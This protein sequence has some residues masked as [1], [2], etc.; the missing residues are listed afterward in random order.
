[1]GVVDR[2]TH[3]VASRPRN[4]IRVP[5][6]WKDGFSMMNLQAWSDQALHA[7]NSTAT[8]VGVA[9]TAVVLLCIVLIYFSGNELTSR[10]M[11]KRETARGTPPNI[12]AREEARPP[13]GAAEGKKAAAASRVAQLEAE[14]ESARHSDD[15]NK[16]RAAQLERELSEARLAEKTNAARLS[17][18]QTDLGKVRQSDEQKESRVAQL[19]RELTEARD[20]EKKTAARLAQLETDLANSR[21]ADEEKGVRLAQMD[22]DLQKARQ[23]TDQA[24]AETKR[25]ESAEGPR[26]ITPEQRKQFIESVRGLPTGKVLVSAFF[27]NPET[28][29][30]GAELLGLLKSAGFSVVERAPLNFFTT[31]R[32]SSGVR[33]GCQDI[34]NPPPH[35]ETVRKALESI[36][37]D[38]PTTNI[39]NADEDD[40]VEIQVTPK[41]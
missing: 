6:R 5:I 25:V 31:S 20:T 7:L 39:V 41:Q 12:F 2:I 17:Q 13:N 22:M 16:A 8:V 36:G 4:P 14:L 15:T 24:K 11:A 37:L 34:N 1:M 30:F 26:L 38:A 33:I 27:E 21:R 35:F 19:E 29:H 32:P 40:V 18:M 9:A 3:N 10:I 28:H 23:S